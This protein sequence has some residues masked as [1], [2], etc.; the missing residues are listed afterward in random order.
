M[1][2]QII[3][4][5]IW[6]TILLYTL[7]LI[8]FFVGYDV[9]VSGEPIMQGYVTLFIIGVAPLVGFLYGRLWE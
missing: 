1:E 8:Y 9:A 7:T 2:T 4:L 3:M 5:K 6:L